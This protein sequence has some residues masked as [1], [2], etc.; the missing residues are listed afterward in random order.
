M[1]HTLL[2]YSS[3]DGQTKKICQAIASDIEQAGQTVQC[4]ALQQANDIDWQ[5]FDKVIIGASIRYG[6][7]NKALATFIARFQ[8]QLEQRV[9]G[10][11]CVNLTARKPD[12]NTPSTNA[13]MRKFLEQSPWRPQ[14]QAVFAGALLYS[15]Y[16]FVDKFMI[17]L[18]MKITGGN[19]DTAQDIE[20]TDWKKVSEFAAI[21]TAQEQ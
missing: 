2:I 10:F 3:N 6:H 21:I 16:G 15:K 11:F 20:Y 14:L 5:E 1:P 4:I 8:E 19:T 17:R 13:Y 18:I 7:F 12:K 9:H